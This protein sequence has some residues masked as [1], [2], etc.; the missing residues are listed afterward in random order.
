MKNYGGLDY[1]DFQD[2]SPVVISKYKL[3]ILPGTEFAYRINKRRDLDVVVN[4]D[5]THGSVYFEMKN[6]P[7]LREEAY[8]DARKDYLQK[9]IFQLSG[10]KSHDADK[11][12]FMS[13]WEAVNTELL[14]YD[15]FGEQLKKNVRI[16]E[17]TSM[18]SSL[19]T[20]AEKMNVVYNY[21]RR[22]MTWNRI[23]SKFSNDGI[24]A[25]WKKKTGTSGD[26]NLLLVNLLKDAGLE[27]YPVLVSERFHGKVNTDY[28][29][30]DQFNS[31]FACVKINSRNYFLDATDPYTPSHITP[32]DILN[33]TGF[34]VKKQSGELINISNDSLQY[35]EV[36]SNMMEVKEDGT[37]NGNIVVQSE[38]YARI[39]KL[40]TNA[41]EKENLKNSYFYNEGFPMDITSFK[42]KNRDKDSLPL[43]QEFEFSSQLISSGE[44]KYIPLNFLPGF[45]KNP[46]IS[47]NRFSNINFGYS[48]NI[49]LSTFI[50]LPASM[51]PDNLPGSV[52]MI[53]PDNNFSFRR[54]LVYDS[55]HHTV[56]CT[57]NLVIK[58]SLVDADD[59][60]TLKEIYKKIYAYLKEPVLL[61]KK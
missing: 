31:V 10:Y 34:I 60:A 48:R 46:F 54:Y 55:N 12:E 9:V 43:E 28:P 11:N 16:D 18:L 20:A 27:A 59:Y 8:M 51:V 52:K 26:I 19:N 4:N 6:I 25:A 3:D 45:K 38:D 47:D 41:K 24:K 53:T 2:E 17:L 21:V 56:T 49:I 22:N 5:P 39:E 23:Y 35:K 57:L 13:S 40:E 42:L 44:Y 36:V 7:G 30:I 58:T 14:K 50:Q 32:Y 33:T 29:F 1:W 37:V 61:K 15:E